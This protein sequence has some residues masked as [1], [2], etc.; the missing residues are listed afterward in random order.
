MP[1]PTTR[2]PRSPL[3][4]HHSSNMEVAA[5]AFDELSSRHTRASPRANRRILLIALIAALVTAIV[6][7][8]AVDNSRTS[9][10]YASAVAWQQK[11]RHRC[12]AAL[13]RRHFWFFNVVTA[14]EMC[15]EHDAARSQLAPL[16]H[17]PLTFLVVGDWGR[18]GM[19]CQ[20]DVAVEMSISAVRLKPR[21]VVGV[22]D[23]FYEHGIAVSTDGQ[24]DRSWRDVYVRPHDSLSGLPW[25]VILGNH[26]HRGEVKAQKVLGRN[27][28]LWGMP[29]TYY[30]ETV[31]DVFMAFLDTTCMYYN[32]EQLK[33]EFTQSDSL[34]HFYR[35]N[36]V[37]AL[38]KQLAETD[39]RWKIVFGHHPF[40]SSAEHGLDEASQRR[41]LQ[42]ILMPILKEHK[43]AAY[44]GGHEHSLE[45][46]E[47]DSINFF[48]SGAGS[49]I[50]PIEMYGDYSRFALDRQGFMA[51]SLTQNS[52]QLRVQVIDLNGHI[53]YTTNLQLP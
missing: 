12:D 1:P 24:V 46:H 34:T 51:F 50:S 13:G 19:C 10:R 16:P 7:I 38:R 49:K 52:S 23:N 53:V 15:V 21:F 45:H 29:D 4:P 36:Q 8:A 40:F 47:K 22:G 44:V 6:I 11:A 39:A 18:D 43:V 30:F 28:A 2:D 17:S 37:A 41:Q 14:N 26:D 31:G 48:V 32:D 25:K 27:D 9:S 33:N 5:D 35:D 3:L 42:T 20:R